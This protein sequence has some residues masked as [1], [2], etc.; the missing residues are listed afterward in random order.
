MKKVIKASINEDV[1]LELVDDAV[2][3]LKKECDLRGQE[4]YVDDVKWGKDRF[5][6]PIFIAPDPR[7]VEEVA[8][9]RFVF[10]PEDEDYPDIE[11]QMHVRLAEFIEDWSSDNSE[12]EYSGDDYIDD[13]ID[14]VVFAY[15]EKYRKTKPIEYI[16]KMA[17]I[18]LTD[19]PY[20]L[21]ED[22]DFT[23]DDILEVIDDYKY[24]W[25]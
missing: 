6:V 8:K 15:L 7:N 2:N 12:E 22:E 24:Y 10:D 13:A 5:E 14:E 9:F 11:D 3:V 1:I 20:N 25:S 18:K 23:V 4:E 17:K 21:V 19:S 16:A